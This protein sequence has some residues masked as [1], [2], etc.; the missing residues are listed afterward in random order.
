[1]LA[2]AFS[3][4]W[5]NCF[6]QQCFQPMHRKRPSHI[7]FTEFFLEVHENKPT[8]Q[9]IYIPSVQGEEDTPNKEMFQTWGVN[10]V[11]AIERKH[12]LI[13]TVTLRRQDAMGYPCLQSRVVWVSYCSRSIHRS[14]RIGSRWSSRPFPIWFY[15]PMIL[16]L[17]PN[18][19]F[20][21]V[22]FPLCWQGRNRSNRLIGGPLHDK[23]RW[24]EFHL[25]SKDDAP[26][27][28]MNTNSYDQNLFWNRKLMSKDCVV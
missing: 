10:S 8:G 25:F 4:A 1:M 6:E 21:E 7:P 16:Q 5:S 24:R 11:I 13:E 15:D 23:I 19:D 17:L 22:L 27:E 26:S 12:H 18:D 28:M 14:R 9:H 3:A 2:S 20:S